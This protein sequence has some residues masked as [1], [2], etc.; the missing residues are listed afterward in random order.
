MIALHD[1]L[2]SKNY[3]VIFVSDQR[4]IKYFNPGVKEKVKIFN[5]NSPFNKKGFSKLMAY[6]QLLVSTIK[7]I[8]F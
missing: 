8:F 2:V 4:A 1:Y 7:S 3:E 5:I 6:Y